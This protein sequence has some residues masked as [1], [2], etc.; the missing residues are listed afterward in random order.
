MP[1]QTG[2]ARPKNEESVEPAAE[3]APHTGFIMGVDPNY[4]SCPSVFRCIVAFVVAVPPLASTG[5]Q[6][7]VRA[8]APRHVGTRCN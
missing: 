8:I 4:P 6:F 1:C 3:F 2:G 5:M 7:V